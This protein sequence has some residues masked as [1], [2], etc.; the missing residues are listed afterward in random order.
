MFCHLEH[1]VFFWSL[2]ML[3][4]QKKNEKWWEHMKLS[5][6]MGLLPE[7]ERD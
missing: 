6:K 5:W 4:E 1:P 3:I 7:C 2:V